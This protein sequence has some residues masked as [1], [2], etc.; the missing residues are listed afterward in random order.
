MMEQRFVKDPDQT[1]TKVVA[2]GAK[3]SG[4]EI[5]VLRYARFKVGEGLEKKADD[6]AEEVAKM[7]GK[8]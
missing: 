1:I 5:S 3:Q 8:N 7:V 4:T 6:F 2:E